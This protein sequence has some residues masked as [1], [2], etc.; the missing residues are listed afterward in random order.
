MCTRTVSALARGLEAAGIAT[1]A[2]VSNRPQAEA[3][4]PPRALYCEFPLG[5]PLGRPGDAAWQRRVLD[6]A[7]ALLSRSDGPVLADFGEAIH[8]EVDTPLACPLPPRRDPTEHPAI[9]E[10]RGL[11]PAWERARARHGGT[12][13]GRVVDAEGLPEAMRALVAV[14]EGAP[15]HEVEVAGGDFPTLL[16]DLR[17]YYEEAALGLSEHVPAARQAESWLYRETRAGDLVRAFYERVRQAEPAFP[18]L[19]YVIPASQV[20]EPLF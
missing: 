20:D 18:G 1:V 7:F 16:M 6:A 12:Q 9:D 11:R 10:A 19:Y 13:V 4:R 2:L 5:R 3:G 15:W 14:A 8:D 17:T